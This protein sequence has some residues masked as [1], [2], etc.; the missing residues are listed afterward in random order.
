MTLAR[1]STLDAG[2]R[3]RLSN[4][5]RRAAFSGENLPMEAIIG[6]ERKRAIRSF[7]RSLGMNGLWPR[8]DAGTAHCNFNLPRPLGPVAS[9]G[10]ESIQTFLAR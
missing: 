7:V 4:V 6:P 2:I 8:D 1:I 5:E 10:M 3:L 9:N